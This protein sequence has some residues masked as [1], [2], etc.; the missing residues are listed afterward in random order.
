MT[1]LTAHQRQAALRRVADLAEILGM[2]EAV[3]VAEHGVTVL[4]NQV[5]ALRWASR[6]TI[7]ADGTP[8]P[9]TVTMV[10]PL[11]VSA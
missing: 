5:T 1:T 6:R 8:V 3:Y 11:E 2:P 9:L 10:R 7:D 4:A